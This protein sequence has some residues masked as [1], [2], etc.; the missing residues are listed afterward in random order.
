[1]TDCIFC[2][3]ISGKIPCNV[4]YEDKHAFAFLDAEPL[5]LGHTLVVPKKH[6]ETIDKMSSV[7]L[8]NLSKAIVKISK[9]ISKLS[10]GMN[11]L[12]NN[13]KVAGQLVPHV[14]FHLVPRY[15]GDGHDPEWKRKHNITAE[16]SE[17]FMKKIK[18]F[19]KQ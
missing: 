9:G 12:Q 2:K 18:S 14:H 15:N 4:I 17:G 19:L 1:M 8:A 7:D 3:L 6:V 10:D 16:Q 13:K 11:I 5:N